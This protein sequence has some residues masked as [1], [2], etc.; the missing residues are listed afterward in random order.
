MLTKKYIIICA[1]Q[2]SGTTVFQKALD[3]TDYIWNCGEIFHHSIFEAKKDNSFLLFQKRLLKRRPNLILPSKSNRREIWR[4]YLTHLEKLTD[5][6]YILLDIKYNSWHHLNTVWYNLLEEPFLVEM[7][8]KQQAYVIQIIRKNKFKQF[9][10]AQAARERQIWHNKGNKQIEKV[11][12][13]IDMDDCKHF[14]GNSIERDKLFSSWFSEYSKYIT[15]NYEDLF[16]NG[17]FHPKVLEAVNALLNKDVGISP[18]PKLKKIN[19]KEAQS[20]TNRNDVI[21]YF[22]QS[23][24]SPMFQDL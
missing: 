11:D 8:K 20:I 12:I 24:Y 2:R 1:Q 4:L 9:I 13:T 10:S 23:E 6:E 15:L 17:V 16:D 18:V 3:G 21:D 7:L 22:S 5:K 14:I 19:T